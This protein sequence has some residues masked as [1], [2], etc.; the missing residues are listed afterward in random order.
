MII[1]PVCLPLMI[2]L[3]NTGIS[4]SAQ[5]IQ[6]ILGVGDEELLFTVRM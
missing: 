6:N 4:A 1:Y 5:Y 2:R 3:V